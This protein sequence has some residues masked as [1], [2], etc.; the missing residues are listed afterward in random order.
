MLILKKTRD[1]A[2]NTKLTKHRK[3]IKMRR[4][5]RCKMQSIAQCFCRLRR[6]Y[7]QRV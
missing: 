7:L 5:R 4:I 1:L 2:G 3:V 6:N